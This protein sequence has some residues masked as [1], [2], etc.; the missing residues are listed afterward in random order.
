MGRARR[1]P[2]LSLALPSW[3]EHAACASHGD[4]DLWFPDRGQDDRQQ[5]ALGI[6]AACPV[7]ESCLAY[8]LSMP[9]QPGIWGGTTEDQR[10]KERRA[11]ARDRK[12][13]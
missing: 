13:S 10:A 7:R 9:P 3:M 11:A 1:R 2:Q 4:P 12:A 8:V 5:E 6:C